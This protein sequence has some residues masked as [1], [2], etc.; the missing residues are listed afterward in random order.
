MV[1]VQ[2]PVVRTVVG[3]ILQHILKYPVEAAAT[4]S[5]IFPLAVMAYRLDYKK[6]IERYFFLYLVSK[7]LIE[8]IMLYMAANVQN[9]LFLYNAFILISYCLLARMCYE[10][11][12][13]ETH[14]RVVFIGSF[15]F[16]FAYGVDLI[17]TGMEKVLRIAPTLQCLFMIVYIML[18][19]YGLL[20]SL[21]VRNL[22]VYPVFWIFSGMLLFYS[23]STFAT[24]IFYYVEQFGAPKDL[25]LIVLVPYVTEILALSLVGLG[26]LV[27]D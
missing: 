19:F 14:K 22:F 25:Y 27:E 20:K 23:S 3:E 4:A 9:N 8:S 7:L 21:K 2:Q 15:L 18:W 26:F 12:D 1:E 16:L 6:S 10:A 24:P 17:D 5:T 11:I 13:I